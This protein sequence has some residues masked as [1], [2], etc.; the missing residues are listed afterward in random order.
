MFLFRKAFH[1]GLKG[2]HCLNYD[3][4]NLTSSPLPI[5]QAVSFI[6]VNFSIQV[7]KFGAKL[8]F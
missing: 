8:R 6:K 2:I 4:Y 7:F 1:E 5:F 3:C